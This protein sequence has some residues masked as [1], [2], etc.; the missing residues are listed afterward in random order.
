MRALVAVASKHGSTREI[1]EVIAEE[2]RAEH[3]TVDVRDAGM[4][5]AIAS[6]DAI[7]F[8]SAV[9]AGS[10]L[11]EARNFAE[12]YKAQLAKVPVWLFSSGPLGTSDPQPQDD[13]AMLAESL[14]GVK[15]RDHHVFV[16]K[17][18]PTNLGFGER[19]IAKAVRAP[20]GDFRDWQ[21]IRTWAQGVAA[22]LLIRNAASVG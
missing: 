22:E 18:D 10:W 8:G 14:S 11:P 17:L 12:R 13:P 6:Y 5:S 9:Y 15:I 4:V 20:S 21:E 7:I 2:L 1:A 19:L 3:F 16:G